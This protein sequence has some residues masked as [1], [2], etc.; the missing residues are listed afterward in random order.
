MIRLLRYGAVEAPTSSGRL[1]IHGAVLNNNPL[2]V[3]ALAASGRTLSAPDEAG[4]TPLELAAQRKQTEVTALLDSLVQLLLPG[5][6]DE[7]DETESSALSNSDS[8]GDAASRRARNAARLRKAALNKFIHAAK[9]DKP[10]NLVNAFAAATRCLRRQGLVFASAP[11][12]DSVIHAVATRRFPGFLDGCCVP[13]SRNTPLH[14]AA[15]H[16]NATCA[17]AL[18]GTGA[19]DVG[20]R[21]KKG[22]TPV[23]IA[24]RKGSTDVLVALAAG[25]ARFDVDDGLLDAARSHSRE[26]RDVV[27]T[28]SA[29]TDPSD[30]MS[31]SAGGG[32]GQ[33]GV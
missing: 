15:S 32:A 7:T 12:A 11:A 20:V 24:A 21:N 22:E 19:A 6:V 1:P 33:G 8:E 13:K 30:D 4:L 10:A 26:M 17:A 29:I 9:T 25:G 16:G 27:E 28:L 23:V 3:I 31:S 2:A 18:V 5:V 14:I